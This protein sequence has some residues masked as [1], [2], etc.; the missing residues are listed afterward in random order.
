MFV[1]IDLYINPWIKYKRLIKYHSNIIIIDNKFVHL[2]LNNQQYKQKICLCNLPLSDIWVKCKKVHLE[3]H[4]RAGIT[5]SS[6][7]YLSFLC[8]DTEKI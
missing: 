8:R 4:G 1:S 6:L 5:K 7:Y 3:T 2:F